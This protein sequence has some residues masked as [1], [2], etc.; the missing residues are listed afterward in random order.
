MPLQIHPE[1]GT[2]VICDFKGFVPPEM[3]KRR[4]AVVISPR[5]RRRQ[6]LCTIIPLSTTPPNP[7]EA[8]HRKLHVGP[9]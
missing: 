6:R 8:Y 3:V 5:L 7:I 2:I 9:V 1:Q 4:P